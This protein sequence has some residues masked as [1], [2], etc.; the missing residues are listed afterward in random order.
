MSRAKSSGDLGTRTD[1]AS[2]APRKEPYWLVM[3]KGRALGYAKGLNGGTWIARYYNP[4]AHPPRAKKALG[5]ADDVSDADG[6]MVL[7]C[8]QAQEAAREWF[9]VAFHE[10]TGE[11]VHVG[12]YTV[13]HA[14]D[15]YIENRKEEGI[16][17]AGRLRQD[18]DAHVI[19]ILGKD[20][21]EHLTQKRLESW[22]RTVAGSGVRRRGKEGKAPESKEEVRARKATT[23]RIWTSLRA[24]LN[25]AHQDKHVQT[26]AGW[27]D[28]RPFRGTQVARIHFLSVA[29]QIRMVNA[30]P[31]DDF[32]RL[33][34]GGL[35]TGAREGE[36]QRLVAKDF[37]PENGSVFF[38]YTKSGK[39]R[40]IALTEEGQA[41]FR[42][43]VAGLDPDTQLF[44]RTTYD[45][46]DKRNSGQWTRPE[47]TRTMR[48]LC[49]A[50][51]VPAMTFHELRHTY[52]STLI[53]A[54]VPLVFVAQQLGHADTRMVEKHYGHLCRTAKTESV[55][56]LTPSLGIHTPGNIA[57]LGMK[58]APGGA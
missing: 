9:K 52:A 49:A 51:S 46:K 41:F 6:K 40:H 10:G 45:R 28:V 43:L 47:M 13:A 1:R 30:C 42:D 33:V 56:R 57:A 50:A 17:T 58:K 14:V 19:P 38:E 12:A 16:A 25:L 44:P 23:N 8:A 4:A 32:R 5:A 34:Q 48:A 2:L 11:R 15:A 7:S 31:S 54:G 37:D 55:R 26:D 22:M 39:P 27:R 24:A 3:E 21:L 53:N 36:L 35:F 29:E 20:V 18:F